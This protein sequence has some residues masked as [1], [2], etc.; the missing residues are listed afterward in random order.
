MKL[1]R[2]YYHYNDIECYSSVVLTVGS[3]REEVDWSLLYY[4]QSL[5]P[6]DR[7]ISVGTGAKDLLEVVV[8]DSIESGEIWD[9]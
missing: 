3:S 5:K 2:A 9:L 1:W 7:L 8:I 6:Q 4:Y